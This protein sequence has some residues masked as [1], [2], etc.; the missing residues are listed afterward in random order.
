MPNVMLDQ[1]PCVLCGKT[2]RVSGDAGSVACQLCVA[3]DNA[4][5]RVGRTLPRRYRYDNWCERC[6]K[7]CKGARCAKCRLVVACSK[8]GG[9]AHIGSAN[10][11]DDNAKATCRKCGWATKSVLSFDCQQCGIRVERR[12]NG[13][14]DRG[15]FCSLKCANAFTADRQ[16]KQ[17]SV[18]CDVCGTEVMRKP[19]DAARARSKSGERGGSFCSKKC[20]GL[21]RTARAAAKPPKPPRAPRS[22]IFIKT[23]VVCGSLFTARGSRAKLCSAQ[24]KIDH[25]GVRV[26]DMYRMATQF[27]DGRYVGAQWRKALIEYLVERDGDKCGIC[28]RRV[29]VTLKSG[30]RGSRKGPSVDHIIPRSLGG[31]D[32]PEN[33]RLTHWGC[34]QQRGNR[35]GGEQLAL[36]G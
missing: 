22:R 34:N 13:S 26:K 30:T 9:D 31:S 2:H 19:S 27:V 25:A 12:K 18:P 28:K 7:N 4:L 36:V 23:C 32:G 14:H 3:L 1:P 16:R 29:D 6:G 21:W 10:Y 35:G 8:C 24:C 20:Y 33:W 5:L 17:V 15:K 11:G